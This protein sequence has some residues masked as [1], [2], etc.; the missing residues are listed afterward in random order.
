MSAGTSKAN[1]FCEKRF[2][3][4]YNTGMSRGEE[5]A[6]HATTHSPRART[7]KWQFNLFQLL[8]FVLIVGLAITYF[9]EFYLPGLGMVLGGFC[10]AHFGFRWTKRPRG[11]L[12]GA[13]CGLF[14]GATI[15]V[16]MVFKLRD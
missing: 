9:R 6:T 1:K 13:I 10:G 2:L 4:R 14:L 8:A 12:I 11:L 7:R 5:K 15:G 16:I 3:C